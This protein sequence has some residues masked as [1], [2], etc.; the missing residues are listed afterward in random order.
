MSQIK[1][2]K[3]SDE[4]R[5]ELKIPDSLQSTADWSVWECEPSS[6]DW[7]Y[8]QIELAYVYEGKVNIKT[9]NGETQINAG[10]FVTFPRDLDCTWEVIEKIRKVYQFI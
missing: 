8:D 6:F 1:V 5:Q 2:E 10:D 9:S 3:L 7:H 4:K